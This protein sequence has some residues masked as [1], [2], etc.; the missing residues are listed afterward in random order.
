[1]TRDNVCERLN[2]AETGI[3]PRSSISS[4][5]H[6]NQYTTEQHYV[7]G[8]LQIILWWWWWWWWWWCLPLLR[9]RCTAVSL[10]TLN[11]F[12]SL[13]SLLDIL[14]N[15]NDVCRLCQP[16]PQ[17]SLA[18]LGL[19]LTCLYSG[20]F[21]C[22]LLYVY[23]QPAD[24]LDWS[25]WNR[26]ETDVGCAYAACKKWAILWLKQHSVWCDD[27]FT[28]KSSMMATI[29]IQIITSLIFLCVQR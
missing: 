20:L 29:Y 8:A 7:M 27:N 16:S 4:P 21:S 25:W 1:M 14:C 5:Q 2:C 3:E 28:Q 11:A 22:S 15:D 10:N 19:L 12:N 23:C 26:T 13:H 6:R 9:I 17:R 18:A 24:V